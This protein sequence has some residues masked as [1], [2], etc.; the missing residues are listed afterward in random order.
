MEDR[1]EK[2]A[3]DILEFIKSKWRLSI[4]EE[5]MFEDIIEIFRQKDIKKQNEIVFL[6]SEDVEE[7]LESLDDD[8]SITRYAERHLGMMSENA[9]EEC[10]EKDLCDY[11]DD[12]LLDEVESRGLNWQDFG[13]GKTD[14]VTQMQ[15]EELVSNFLFADFEKRNKMLEL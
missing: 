15:L 12:E 1:T 7:L 13:G 10:D 8:W 6:I 4:D 11:D 3:E 14:I 9:C 2:Q 5:E